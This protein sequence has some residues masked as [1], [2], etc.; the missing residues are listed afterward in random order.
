VVAFR[1]GSGDAHSVSYSGHEVLVGMAALQQQ[2]KNPANTFTDIR[3]MLFNT[4]KE[5][6]FIPILDKEIPIEELASHLF[7]HVYNQVNQQ[8]V[9][10][11][12]PLRDSFLCLPAGL[13][14][15]AAAAG[16]ARMTS[17]ASSGGLRVKGFCPEGVSPLVA[18]GM[19]SPT[20]GPHVVAAVVDMGWSQTSVSFYSISNGIF[21]PLYSNVDK[22]IN[23]KT[24]NDS[25]VK[26]CV[27]DF[28]R[29]CKADCSDNKRSLT[30][31]ALQCEAGIKI[32]LSCQE[33]TI[34][35]DSLFEGL[36]YAGKVTRSRFQDLCG[37]TSM[38][39][40]NFLKS[41]L[42]AAQLQAG[43][44]SHVLFAGGGGA[45]PFVHTL[46]RNMF[47]HAIFPKTHYESVELGCAGAAI[48]GGT[49]AL[50]TATEGA[51]PVYSTIKDDIVLCA[52]KAITADNCMSL[53]PKNTI[54]PSSDSIS[55]KPTTKTCEFFVYRSN[56]SAYELLGEVCFN[57][58][59]IGA[60]VPVF[61]RL[62]VA[63]AGVVGLTVSVGEKGPS[64]FIPVS[65]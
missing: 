57:T 46:V 37:S 65:A 61:F 3:S 54:L 39:L 48:H 13:S 2:A 47:E 35:V 30:R 17:G 64:F 21:C 15:A 38:G 18:V 20:S 8:T 24:F 1:P 31:L 16:Q 41:S 63:E 22:A 29:R 12:D 40:K 36:D 32:L 34:V 14:E 5:R 43:E 4:E 60:E 7:R 58:Q 51:E 27:K 59:D 49:A 19:D 45:L 50:S 44:V 52:S 28:A 62:A 56:G 11:K 55:L 42:E 9:S 53:F 23:A 26:F 25:L 6:I 10:K 33:T